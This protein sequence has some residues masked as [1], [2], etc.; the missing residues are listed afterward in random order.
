M[1]ASTLHLGLRTPDA[2]TFKGQA[3]LLLRADFPEEKFP[4]HLGLLFS[5]KTH[6]SSF[7]EGLST[8]VVPLLR[9][10]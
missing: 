8:H 6:T 9:R 5:K 7:A 10:T 1:I 2:E 4:G 3:G